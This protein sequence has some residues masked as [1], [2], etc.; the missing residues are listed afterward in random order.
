MATFANPSETTKY[1]ALSTGSG[2]RP[3]HS[4][5]TVTGTGARCTSVCTAASRPRS[6]NTAGWMPRASSRSSARLRLSSSCAWSSSTACSGSCARLRAIRSVNDSATSR[7]CAPSCRSRS[8]LRR[9][10]SPAWTSRAREARSSS[11]VSCSSA[12]RCEIR[13]RVRPTM[14]ANGINPVVTNAPHQAESLSAAWAI[15]TS[16]NVSRANV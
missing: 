2:R 3:A 4:A 6:V 7:D 11:I 14:N 16:A 1:A 9:A 13:E 5:L 8:S 12:S 10:A 15:V